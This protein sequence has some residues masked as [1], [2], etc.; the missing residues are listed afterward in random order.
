MSSQQ[1]RWQNRQRK[2]TFSVL[3]FSRFHFGGTVEFDYRGTVCEYNEIARGLDGGVDE[4]TKRLQVEVCRIGSSL[5]PL[6]TA[7]GSHHAK[8]NHSSGNFL[9]SNFV[10]KIAALPTM[11]LVASIKYLESVRAVRSR[12]FTHCQQA[13]ACSK[14]FD[15]SKTRV[16]GAAIQV[17]TKAILATTSNS[18]GVCVD[19]IT[20]D[21][22]HCHLKCLV[23]SV[24]IKV[25]YDSSVNLLIILRMTVVLQFQL[26]FRSGTSKCRLYYKEGSIRY[27]Q[28]LGPIK[29][30]IASFL[31][32]TQVATINRKL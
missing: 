23:R 16:L 12:S 30:A 6:N 7:R 28:G 3:L 4:R 26:S 27:G 1:Q 22:L 20:L 29:A 21:L 15:F 18:R 10:S 14:S 9:Q 5:H 32:T 8:V 31:K 11:K 19:S 17:T 25:K 2:K 24:P 13:T